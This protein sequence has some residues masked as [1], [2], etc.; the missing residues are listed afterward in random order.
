[1]AR[2]QIE[3]VIDHLGPEIKKALESTFKDHFPGANY[4]MTMLFR[5]FRKNMSLR[6]KT[7]A[8]IPDRFVQ[9][10]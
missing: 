10:D 2:I 4:D 6:Y 7:W 8:E 9:K 3:E 5:S 1:M